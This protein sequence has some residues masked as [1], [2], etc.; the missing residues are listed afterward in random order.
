MD[1][2]KT[3]VYMIGPSLKTQGGIS[4]VLDIYNKNFRE[5]L[6]LRFI[7]SYYGKSRVLDII[8]FAAAV[9]RVIW[10]NLSGDGIFHIHVASNGSYLR[11]SILAKICM[12]FRHRVILHVHG[13]MFDK[14]MEGAGQKKRGRIIALFN[15]ADSVVVLSESWFS[16]FKRFVAAEKLHVIYNPSSTFRAG[17]IRRSRTGSTRCGEAGPTRCSEARSAGSSETVSVG[18]IETEMIQILFM[19][20]FG[21]RKGVY[22]LIQAAAKLKDL[23]FRLNLYGDGEISEVR[24][25]VEEK[26]LQEIVIVNGWVSHSDI[27]RIYEN[28]DVMVLPSYA[29]G[30]PMSLLEAIGEGLPVVSTCVGGIPEAVEEGRN[31]FLIDQGDVD[32]LAERLRTLITSP[33]LVDRMGQESL[34]IAR[35]KFSTDRIGQQLQQLYQSL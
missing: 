29:E 26:Q 34:T 10:A 20:R 24:K 7:S 33:E 2:K 35:E 17:S 5:L 14:F 28:A 1:G 12:A 8:L 6:N 27:S 30:L 9:I 23:P 21:R 4:S 19:G 13:A 15:K 32:A 16:Y 25:L 22:D 11:K 31:G 3:K 18:I